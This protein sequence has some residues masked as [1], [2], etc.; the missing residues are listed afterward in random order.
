MAQQMVATER[1]AS[2]G[3]LAAGVAHEINNPLAIIKEAAGWMRLL[4]QKEELAQMP[5][6]NDFQLALEKIESGVERAR[7]ITHQLLGFV[8]KSD[9]V[10]SE[11][12]LKELVEEAVQLVQREAANKVIEI[13]YE[14]DSSLGAIW[15]D[16]YRIRQ[17]L[18][19]LLTN[20]IHATGPEGKIT[21]GTMAVDN[22][23]ALTVK[24]TGT[25]IPKENL[26]KIFDPFFS[27]K[28]PGQGTGL[29]LFVTRGLVEKLGG[30]IQVES[31]LGQGSTFRV[32]LPKMCKM[33]E[34]LGEESPLDLL[35]KAGR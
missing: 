26:E 11:V 22:E 18:M 25:G 1:L 29:G 9:T 13:I 28:S 19:N 35:E 27:T 20:A 14:M 24:D 2:L 3:T 6:K 16:P 4:L 23:I 7:R 30:S 31:R 33:P 12:D 15:C 32:I 34:Q 5:R 8:R 17:V 21:V 10:P